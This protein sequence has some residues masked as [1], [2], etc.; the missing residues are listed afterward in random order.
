MPG[1]GA[2]GESLPVPGFGTQI[3]NQAIFGY[4]PEAKFQVAFS[5]MVETLAD[6]TQVVLKNQL[7]LWLIPTYHFQEMPFCH[8]E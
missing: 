7:T 2:S 8:Q 1:Q 4:Q 3:Q 6:G 5:D